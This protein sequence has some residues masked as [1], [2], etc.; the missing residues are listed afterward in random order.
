VVERSPIWGSSPTTIPRDEQPLQIAHDIID[1]YDRPAK[2]H[3]L[4]DRA[5]AIRWALGEA[6]R[7]TRC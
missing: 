4:P 6:D 2:A 5:E 7:V 1:G 3:I